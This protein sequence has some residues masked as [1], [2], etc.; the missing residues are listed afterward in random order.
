MPGTTSNA[1][2]LPPHVDLLVAFTNSVDHELGT[3]DLTTP[4]ELT[5]W[6][7][8]HRLLVRST[9]STSEDVALARRLR[10]GLHVALVAHHD[11]EEDAGAQVEASAVDSQLQRQRG[12][13]FD[14][15][16]GVLLAVVVSH[17]GDV[18][19]VARAGAGRGARRPR[20]GSGR[21][22]R[23]HRGR[24]LAAAEDLCGGRLPVGLR[25]H[26]QEPLPRLVRVGLR[27]QGQDPQLSGPE[28][29]GGRALAVGASADRGPGAPRRRRVPGRRRRRRTRRRAAASAPPPR[30]TAAPRP[31]LLRRAGARPTTV[32]TPPTRRR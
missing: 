24:H 8:D 7:V 15:C 4:A 25:R 9:R 17:Q 20:A 5:R 13:R 21:R 14:Q 2:P 19:A 23:R 28:E 11:G 32:R 16:T 27:Q 30:R 29:G 1:S 31:G 18:Q 12:G 26:H 6:L 3:D 10:D 22:D